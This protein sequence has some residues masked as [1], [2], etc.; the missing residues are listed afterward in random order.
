MFAARG[1]GEAIGHHGELLQGIFEDEDAHQLHRGLM[2]LPSRHLKSTATFEP[3]KSGKVTVSP[4]R[5]EKARRAADLTLHV[6]SQIET[7]GHLTI[8]SKI[9]VG[10]GMGSSTADVLAS[11]LAVLDHLGVDAPPD[12]VMEIAVRAETACDSTL[13]KQAVL[14]A[15]R[16]GIV[17]ESFRRSL[18]PINL[19]SIDT[20]ADAIVDT[21]EFQPARYDRSEIEI[22]RPLRSLLRRA[23]K[24]SDPDLLGRVATASA[25][26]N[27]RFLKKPRLEDI[28]AIGARYGAIGIQVAH[29]GTIVGIMFDPANKRTAENMEL[30]SLHLRES[31]FEPTTFCH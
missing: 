27:E 2:S 17:I 19:I 29:S 9:P 1:Y 20:M 15:H 23:I 10:R 8:K 21:L 18:P 7:S 6:F 24:T 26:I 22:F 14:F 30:T 25:W 3:N 28:E 16:E 12:R 31:G 11:I 13:F 5:C 4:A